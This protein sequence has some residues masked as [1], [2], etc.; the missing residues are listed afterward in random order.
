[1]QDSTPK[2]DLLKVSSRALYDE[3]CRRNIEIEIIDA[4]LSFME[5]KDKNDRKRLLFS[6]CSD[7]SSAAGVAIARNKLRT[8]VIARRLGI[9]IPAYQVCSNISEAKEFLR[10]H[11]NIVIKPISNG[12]GNGVTTNID[13]AEKLNV[14]LAYCKK[15]GSKVI[16]QEH[17][18]GDDIRI[19]IAGN[20]FVSAVLRKPACVV[21]DG[22]STVEE[23]IILENNSGKRH[24]KSMS[25]FEFIKTSS[26]K[27]YL[28][29][30]YQSVP[31]DGIEIRVM[32]PANVSLGGSVHEFSSEV[33]E[34][35]IY[36]AEKITKKLGL[37]LCGV[38]LMWDRVADRYALIEINGVPG[39]NMHNSLDWGTKSGAI[40]KYVDWLI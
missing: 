12:R 40:E 32:G 17:F 10:V 7:K 37:G 16:A 13:T 19:L 30:D 20:N 11:K 8:A 28:G 1:M 22:V 29:D 3:F 35:M 26:A 25:A 5:Y 23:L 4:S 21:G 15:F 2:R 36:D 39:I 6:T 38:D 31:K 24:S 34:S 14:A 9:P 27:R 18:E 33:T